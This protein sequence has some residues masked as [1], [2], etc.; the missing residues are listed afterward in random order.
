MDSLCVAQR[1]DGS[2]FPFAGLRVNR[3][4]SPN[5]P[6]RFAVMPVFSPHQDQALAAVS[7]WLKDK[8][9]GS[10]SIFRLF[11]YAGTGKTTLARHIADSAD[12]EVLFAAFTG[13]A[14]QVMRNKGCH[15]ASTIHSLIYRPLESN[16]EIPSFQLFDD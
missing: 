15:G 3:I 16:A 6:N 10:C 11:G 8:P 1:R 13:K 12:G 7:A 9:S 14:A 4:R 5:S 2:G